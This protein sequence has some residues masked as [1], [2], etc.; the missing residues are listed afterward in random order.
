M[1]NIKSWNSFV[2]VLP[3]VQF[4]PSEG[5]TPEEAMELIERVPIPEV[6][7]ANNEGAD[8]LRID[9]DIDYSDPFLDKV[10]EVSKYCLYSITQLS[11]KI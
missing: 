1:N 4:E 8:I 9:H 7:N 11:D 3:L 5:I 10:E 6:E 2:E